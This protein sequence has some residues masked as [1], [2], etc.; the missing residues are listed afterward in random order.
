[1]SYQKFTVV[2]VPV[3]LSASIAKKAHGQKLKTKSITRTL[4]AQTMMMTSERVNF[5]TNLKE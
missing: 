5:I 2:N 4:F 3:R 1:M